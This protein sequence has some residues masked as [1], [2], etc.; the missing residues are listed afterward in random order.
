MGVG[1]GLKKWGPT[2]HLSRQS[3][4]GLGLH[5]ADTTSTQYYHGTTTQW[6][7]VLSNLNRRMKISAGCDESKKKMNAAARSWIECGPE[8]EDY[9]G[10]T[11]KQPSAS[12]REKREDWQ[13]MCVWSRHI[14]EKRRSVSELLI[15]RYV[16]SDKFCIV[17]LSSNL[18]DDEV[19]DRWMV[20]FSRDLQFLLTFC[21]LFSLSTVFRLFQLPL[22]CVIYFSVFIRFS[23]YNFMKFSYYLIK[24]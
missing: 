13:T 22:T 16:T 23:L 7:G 11:C 4:T 18:I 14:S 10:H 12:T 24:I 1:V 8:R 17:L 5:I 20:R 19:M 21:H 3:S 9:G 2:A 6:S 15:I